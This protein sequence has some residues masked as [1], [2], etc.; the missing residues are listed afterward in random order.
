MT[1]GL[2]GASLYI[3]QACCHH[4]SH[5]PDIQISKHLY[6]VKIPGQW[7]LF[8]IIAM[9]IKRMSSPAGRFPVKGV[10]PEEPGNSEPGSFWSLSIVAG[11]KKA[12]KSSLYMQFTLA[13]YA[14]RSGRSYKG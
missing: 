1:K 3:R 6:R 13:L 8:G 4:G 12:G 7:I 2:F 11:G 14:S 9:T 5:E 10:V